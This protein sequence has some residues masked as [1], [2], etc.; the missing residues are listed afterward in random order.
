MNLRYENQ[1][2]SRGYKF[3]IGCDEVGRGCLA[4]PV[5]AAAVVFNFKSRPKWLSEIKDS[6]QLLPEKREYLSEKIKS[7]AVWSIG[8]VSSDRVDEINIHNASLLAMKRA[9][10]KLPL[11]AYRS[12]HFLYVDGKFLVPNI[13]IDQ[14]A[15][16][17]GDNK[18][19][20]VAAASIIAKVYRDKLMQKLHEQYPIY[21]FLQHKGYATLYHRKMI[22]QNG[23]SPIHRLS[24][25][26]NLSV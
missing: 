16:I 23:L 5:V 18:V 25:C 21:N 11:G 15:I 26:Q 1:K 19:L 13:K 12:S 6:K 14:E 3:I 17:G 4:G 24:F 2:T 20:S 9:I 22:I 8:E 10:E 7:Q